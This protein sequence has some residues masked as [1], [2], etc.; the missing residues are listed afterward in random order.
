MAANSP[1]AESSHTPSLLAS[2]ER[3]IKIRDGAEHF[4]CNG[5][6]TSELRNQVYK[7]MIAA[8]SRIARMQLRHP[9]HIPQDPYELLYNLAKL[10]SSREHYALA[11]AIMSRLTDLMDRNIRLKE[12]LPPEDLIAGYVH[13]LTRCFSHSPHSVFPALADNVGTD[14]RAAAY[15]LVRHAVAAPPWRLVHTFRDCGLDVFLTRTLLRDNRCSSEKEQALKLVRWVMECGAQSAQ[16]VD[17]GKLVTEN[18]VRAMAAAAEQH[19]EAL[20]YLCIETLGELALLDI[21]SLAEANAIRTL[22]HAT[23]DT[24]RELAPELLATLLVL[25]DKPGTRAVFKPGLDL[26]VALSAF[27]DDRGEERE[28]HLKLASQMAFIMLRSWTG[29]LYMCINNRAALRSLVSALHINSS[30]MQESILVTLCNFFDIRK[31]VSNHEDTPHLTPP[32]FR[33]LDVPPSSSQVNLIESYL[34]LVASILSEENIVDA[35]VSI[36][37]NR[38]SLTDKAMKLLQQLRDIAVRNMSGDYPYR[39][40]AQANLFAERFQGEPHANFEEREKASKVLSTLDRFN[41]RQI[42]EQK[43]VKNRQRSDSVKPTLPRQAVPVDENTFRNLVLESNVLNTRDHTKWSLDTLLTLFDG[44]LLN[45]KRLEEAM[46]ASKLVRRVLAFYHPFSVRYSTLIKSTANQRY[47]RLGC[48]VLQTLLTSAD[49]MKFLGEDKLLV[50]IGDCL[51]SEIMS[52]ARFE[53][54][55]ASGYIDFLAV[56]SKSHE[57]LQLMQ[58]ARIFSGLYKLMDRDRRVDVAHAILHQLDFTIDGHCR[59]LLERI[60]THTSKRLRVEAT[61]RIA[62]L[63]RGGAGRWA[64]RL[65]VNQLYDASKELRELTSN[66]L[67]QLCTQS[68]STL[69]LVVSLRPILDEG[70]HALL[71]KFLSTSHGLRYLTQSQYIDKEMHDWFHRRNILYTTQVEVLLSRAFHSNRTKDDPLLHW[72]GNVPP[73]FYGELV[74][75]P[76]GCKVLE[77]KGHFADFARF[78]REHAQEEKDSRILLKLKSI[79][80][81]VGNIGASEGGVPFLEAEDIVKQII[82]MA[83]TTAVFSLRGTCYFVLTLLATT[84]AGAELVQDAGWVVPAEYWYHPGMTY[85]VCLPSPAFLSIPTWTVR[86]PNASVRFLSPSSRTEQ[87][88]LQQISNL[89]NAILVTKA[90]RS[91]AKLK[92]RNPRLFIVQSTPTD[93]FAGDY[94]RIN[95]HFLQSTADSQWTCSAA[96]ELFVRVLHLLDTHPFRHSIRKYIWELFDVRLNMDLVSDMMRCRIR[97]LSLA[98]TNVYV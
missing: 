88:I 83:N 29:L 46:R 69:E 75:T 70:A 14:M 77:S 40:Q 87:A 58:Q 96:L 24:A 51:T 90:S 91:L 79:L 35:I 98:Q 65:L 71:L 61:K 52:E 9:H 45:P 73:H 60:L 10:S 15:R 28:D 55:M 56:L 44:V 11:I 42:A 33:P 43:I 31:D 41:I 67:L 30:S 59:I 13:E 26:D 64:V 49:S 22:L 17:A 66:T 1:H 27:T 32:R 7:E 84:Q 16:D 89:G 92:E 50:E 18:V 81:A 82:D 54:T 76:E 57:G 78:I 62:E 2:F 5:T 8:H 34:L 68:T 25:V 19:D 39:L 93:S 21:D 23:S 80:W 38:P 3:E 6:G 12:E 86:F 20:R 36:L 63:I 47:T 95:G 53:S 85:R 72:D 4:L 48:A 94:K 97:L 74:K 37:Q